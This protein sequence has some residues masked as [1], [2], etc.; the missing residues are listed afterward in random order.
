MIGHNHSV[1]L[2]AGTTVDDKELLATLLRE[3]LS[4]K[5][6]A[7]AAFAMVTALRQ[8]LSSR[9]KDF[10]SEYVAQVETLLQSMPTETNPEKTL[11]ILRALLPSAEA[12]E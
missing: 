5:I 1:F 3:T 8:T 4:T 2:K 10:D 9:S 11:A 7:Q 6:Q 12:T